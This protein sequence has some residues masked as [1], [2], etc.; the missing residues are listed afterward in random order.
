MKIKSSKKIGEIMPDPQINIPAS[1]RWLY[2]NPEA[3]RVLAVGLQ[4]A[5]EGK[6][7]KVNPDEL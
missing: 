2:K 6:V 4:E 3:R 1:E 5:S 7:T